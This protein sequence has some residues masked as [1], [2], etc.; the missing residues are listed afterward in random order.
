MGEQLEA[1]RDLG[2]I[3]ECQFTMGDLQRR[4]HGAPAQLEAMTTAAMNG[5]QAVQTATGKGVQGLLQVRFPGE[6]SAVGSE[7]CQQGGI[8]QSRRDLRTAEPRMPQA[9]AMAQTLRSETR[10]SGR[11]IGITGAR[12]RLG[13][14]L[15][16][17]L[18]ARGAHVV[19]LTHSRPGASSASAADFE[20]VV[21]ECGEEEALDD[22]LAALD[23][24]VINH[25]VNP[26]GAQDPETLNRAIEVNALSAWRLMQRFEASAKA[27]AGGSRREVW[28]NTSEAEIQP[29]LSPAYELSKRLIGQLVTLRGANLGPD[30]RQHL[31]IRKLV[32]GPFRSE[33]N[34]I[35]VMAAEFVVRQVLMQVGLGLRLV[36]VTPNPLTYVLMPLTELGR[37]LYS[38][39]LSRPG[40]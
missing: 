12:G 27:S 19:G 34:P 31:V 29:A 8:R 32:L 30:L 18:Q 9:D 25:G 24:L 5:T 4:V 21:W 20:W 14:A 1:I 17:E 15:G 7:Q 23:I 2:L 3:R 36:I 16:L 33:L 11:R 35:G 40:R 39:A 37:W 6:S 22:C 13:Q 26:Q 10:W 38:R 28:V